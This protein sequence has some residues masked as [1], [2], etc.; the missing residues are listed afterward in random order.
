VG[1][2]KT[3]ARAYMYQGWRDCFASKL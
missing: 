1:N 3:R 2:H